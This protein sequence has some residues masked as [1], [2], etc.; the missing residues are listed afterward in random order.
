MGGEDLQVLQVVKTECHFLTN[1]KAYEDIWAQ[2]KVILGDGISL[3]S[4]FDDDKIRQTA[5]FILK[6]RSRRLDL[7]KNKD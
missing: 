1:C 3:H 7:E 5:G 4:L 2:Y 6:I